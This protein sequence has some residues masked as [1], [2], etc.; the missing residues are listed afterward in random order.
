MDDG[1]DEIEEQEEADS[2]VLPFIG[3]WL[4][5]EQQCFYNLVA[6]LEQR[7]RVRRLAILFPNQHKKIL[8]YG[9]LG[10]LDISSDNHSLTVSLTR[11]RMLLCIGDNLDILI[12]YLQAE[13]L[14]YLYCFNPKIHR[15]SEG[16]EG[17]IPI[18]HDIE[19]DEGELSKS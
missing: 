4:P 2:H 1:D 14:P 7:E 5:Q 15:I 18:I 10:E 6:G 16:Q 8:P 17:N 19:I 12:P 9:H 13:T 3:G 11:D